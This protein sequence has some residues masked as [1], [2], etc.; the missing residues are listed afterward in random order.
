MY[1]YIY[2]LDI[3]C[4]FGALFFSYQNK[5]KNF[6]PLPKK[7][8]WKWFV[9]DCSLF[10]YS[11]VLKKERFFVTMVSVIGNVFLSGHSLWYENWIQ[12]GCKIKEPEKV[13]P[14]NFNY[15]FYW[16]K[17]FISNQLFFW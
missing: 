7:N 12:I 11:N 1:C 2:S 8:L 9:F 14:T 3:Y 15:F 17:L 10:S 16:L 6:K 13:N 4:W 5:P